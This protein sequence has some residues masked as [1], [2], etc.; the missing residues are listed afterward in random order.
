MHPSSID[1]MAAFRR[2]YLEARRDEPLAILDLGACD[3]NGSYR[4]LFA[5]PRWRY[6]GADLVAGENVDLVLPNAYEWRELKSAS[7]DVVIS[8]QTLEHTEFFWETMLEIARV[9]KPGGLC[10]VIV[11]SAGPEHRFPTDCWR[12]YP[13]GL[14]AMARYAGL[15]TLEA[16][17]QW[18][19]LPQY[20]AVSNVW[21][22]SVLIA[23][24]PRE[25]FRQR[26][27]RGFHRWLKQRLPLADL[28][29]E[30]IVQIY[31]STDGTLREQDSLFSRV[32]HDRWE[33]ISIALPAAARPT[34][35]R[36]DFM[37]P[38]P[39]SISRGFA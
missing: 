18:N 11:P 27:R 3:I 37:G 15:E 25:D 35:L 10:C 23:R 14:R 28:A 2:D 1:Q 19:E 7:R 31:F 30:T 13:D 4:A 38:S 16:R 22:D 17:T 34:P 33:T 29:P 21:H 5:E 24:K 12:F 26:W 32:G 20:D 39:R 6:Q 9:L 36:I 8:G